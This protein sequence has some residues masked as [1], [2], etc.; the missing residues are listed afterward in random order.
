M[1]VEH[2]ATSL[3]RLAWVPSTEATSAYHQR[4]SRGTVQLGG[5]RVASFQLKTF[6]VLVGCRHCSQCTADLCRTWPSRL[7]LHSHQ[8]DQSFITQQPS[9][10]EK[11]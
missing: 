10:E 6:C 9:W 2:G 1:Y 8:I 11:A 5:A 4:S 7:A 3:Q